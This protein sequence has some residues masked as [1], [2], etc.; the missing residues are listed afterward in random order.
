[1]VM[2]LGPTK[3]AGQKPGDTNDAEAEDTQRSEETVQ[4]DRR[5][6]DPA[7]SRGEESDVARKGQPEVGEAE[8][9]LPARQA[10]SA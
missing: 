4:G 6:K 5:R 2:V 8:A 3:N 1:M 9:E 10:S 7:P